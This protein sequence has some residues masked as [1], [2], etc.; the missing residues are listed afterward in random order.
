MVPEKCVIIAGIEPASS[1]VVTFMIPELYVEILTELFIS[2]E[3]FTC[4][5]DL[6]VD[7]VEIDADKQYRTQGMCH[8][9]VQL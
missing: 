6:G 5:L 1:I 7:V 2:N 9:Y 4:L 3:D 8:N